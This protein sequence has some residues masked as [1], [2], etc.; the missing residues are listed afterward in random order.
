MKDLT[1]FLFQKATGKIVDQFKEI[2]KISCQQFLSDIITD[3][4]KTALDKE[5]ESEPKLIEPEKKENLIETTEEEIEAYHIVKSILRKDI[6]PARITY[7]DFQRF[8]SILIDDSIRNTVCR[9]YFTESNK[10]IAFLKDNK[11]EEREEM[12][13]IDDIYRFSDKIREC[14]RRFIK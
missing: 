10:I 1:P 7:R 6:E 9:F 13:S 5:K 14:T 4:L 3:R 8:F 2:V 12:T 11:T